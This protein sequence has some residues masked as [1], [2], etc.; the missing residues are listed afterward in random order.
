MKREISF[1][2][3]R[4]EQELQEVGP[5]YWRDPDWTFM[6]SSGHEHYTAKEGERPLYPTLKWHPVTSFDEDGEEIDSGYYVCAICG[7]KVSP[8]TIW[9]ESH[10]VGGGLQRIIGGCETSMSLNPGD[11]CELSQLIPDAKHTG[12]V[13]IHRTEG[14][15]GKSTRFV[16][17]QSTGKMELREHATL[18]RD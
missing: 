6:D 5:G 12:K 8:G 10:L 18:I 16:Q 9:K 11:E 14:E 3:Y 17:F 2:K 15:F 4:V 13:I 1:G 7:E